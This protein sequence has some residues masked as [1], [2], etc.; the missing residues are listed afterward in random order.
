MCI[1]PNFVWVERGPSFEK[2]PRP[3]GDCWRCRSNRVNDYTGRCLAELS[4]SHSMLS[5]TLTYA[6]RDDLCDKIIE[7]RHFQNFIRALRKR[8]HKLRYIAVGEYGKNTDRAHFHAILFK[9]NAKAWLNDKESPVVKDQREWVPEWPHGH[10]FIDSRDGERAVRYVTKYLLKEDVDYWLTMSKK[11]PLGD[12]FFRKK[13]REAGKL[14]FLPS[15]FVYQPPGGKKERE[16]MMTGATQRN[17]TAYCVKAYEAQ[18]GPLSRERR[19]EWFNKALDKVE[20]WEATREVD[21][22]SSE[23]R[24]YY[25]NE[26]DERVSQARKAEFSESKEKQW[27]DVVKA[28]ANKKSA[29]LSDLR[30]WCRKNNLRKL[31]AQSLESARLANPHWDVTNSQ[32]RALVVRSKG[33]GSKTTST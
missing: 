10:I 9:K 13:A 18:H 29:L 33:S 23:E 26:Q 5:V 3:C 11:P 31:N 28:A 32:L 16:Y 25:E 14:G 30:D 27:Q 4:E 1:H 12:E 22:L 2:I 7:P 8:G 20:R 17:F 15:S 6:P 21:S 24:L 19:S